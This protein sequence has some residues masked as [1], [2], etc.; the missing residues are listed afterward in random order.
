MNVYQCS[1]AAHLMRTEGTDLVTTIDGLRAIRCQVHPNT[2]F[3]RQ[4]ARFEAQLKGIALPAS[5]GL[6]GL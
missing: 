3:L 1:V 4:L 6:D 5:E 2:G